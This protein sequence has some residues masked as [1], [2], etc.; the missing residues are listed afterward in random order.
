MIKLE[1]NV[2]KIEDNPGD[3]QYRARYGDKILG[4]TQPASLEEL[5]AL[6]VEA[7][8]ANFGLH[9]H[10]FGL[11]G[12]QRLNNV[13]VVDLGRM[14]QIIEVNARAAYALVEPGVTYQQL[15]QHLQES[16]SG[17]WIDPDRNGMN[18]VAASIAAHEFGYTPYG[19][20]V[21]MQCGSEVM[22][23]NG[24]LVRLGMGALPGA[25]TWQLA[26][27]A[28]GPYVDGLFTQSNLGIVT[29]I[30]VWLMPAPPAY[31]PFMLTLQGEKDIAPAVEILRDL[32]INVIVP[33]SVVISN[34][35]LDAAPFKSRKDYLSEGSVDANKLK[36]DTD[37]GEWNIYGAL[38]NTPDNVEVLWP[39]VSQALTS[40]E[41]ARLFTRDDRQDD[42]V[43]RAR[44]GLMRGEP[45]PGFNDLN[46][47]S[48]EYRCDLGFA[49]PPDGEE[50]LKL[51][52][53][54]AETLGEYGFDD[55]GECVAGWRAIIRRSYLLFDNEQLED[56]PR[57]L[58][59]LIS[60]ADDAGFGL[61]HQD[62]SHP[63]LYI[64]SNTNR[65]LNE[66]QGRL[67]HALDPGHRFY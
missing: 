33:N 9:I 1:K 53:I 38:Y 25:N 15:Y 66:L 39:M 55:M 45:A 41:G 52:Q 43:W 65:G 29:K 21:M 64:S 48:G 23:A 34:T 32:K 57:R 56:V 31:R 42:P 58:G 50:I 13:V 20:H 24:E 35:L 5:R 62:T 28:Y 63:E 46:S 60:K 6:V 19:D 67:K 8:K 61:T 14:N 44:E 16:N 4:V 22:L 37:L 3:G 7:G 40:I 10:G 2:P 36:S 18:S 17:L 49:C 12:S 59:E 27:Y 30:G 11:A 47:W 26:K 51:N 54:V